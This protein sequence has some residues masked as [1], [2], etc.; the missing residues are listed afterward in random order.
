MVQS[1]IRYQ[2]QLRTRATHGPSGSSIITDAPL[3]NRGK[4][5]AFSPTDLVGVALGS[6]VLTLMGI[7]AQ[8][9]GWELDGAEV[10][11]SKKMKAEP[12][13]HIARLNVVLS[14]PGEWSSGQ[15]EALEASAR[16][17]PVMASLGDRVQVQ[18]SFVWGT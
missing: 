8:D 5:Q 15:R 7:T 4:G 2:G 3:D 17:C 10:S 14:I 9:N 16:G 13:R 1:K 12:M 18:M 11:V 6:C